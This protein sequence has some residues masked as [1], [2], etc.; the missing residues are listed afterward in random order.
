MIEPLKIDCRCGCGSKETISSSTNIMEYVSRVLGWSSIEERRKL[1]LERQR[2]LDD[3]VSQS[4]NECPA[5]IAQYYL[6]QREMSRRQ[7]NRLIESSLTRKIPALKEEL[8]QNDRYYDQLETAVSSGCLCQRLPQLMKE[9]PPPTETPKNP[10]K[11]PPFSGASVLEII[12]D[13]TQIVNAGV[14]LAK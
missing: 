9:I 6:H 1:Q 5:T 11:N 14:A 12:K 10:P 8:D 3:Q 2:K 4:V 7:Q 13:K